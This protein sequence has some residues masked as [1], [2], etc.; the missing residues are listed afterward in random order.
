MQ[1]ADARTLVTLLHLRDLA[2]RAGK[3]LAIA[4]EMLDDRNRALAQ[5]TRVDD[6][7]VS[8]RLISLLVTQ[9][10]ENPTLAAVF[11]ELF[12]AEGS[13]VY[14]RPASEYVRPG[15]RTNFA[16]IVEAA[17]RRG[18]TAIGYRVRAQAND[19]TAAYGVH[20]NPPKSQPVSLADGD[21]VIVLALD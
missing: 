16:T 15:A 2:S 1:R 6:V 5:V 9:I 20:V 21:R 11:D 7:I 12:T 3:Q 13:E 10:S 19:E 8:D 4:S 14:L 17:R 18:E